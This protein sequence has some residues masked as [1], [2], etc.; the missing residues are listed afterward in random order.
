MHTVSKLMLAKRLRVKMIVLIVCCCQSVLQV[1]AYLLKTQLNFLQ[2]AS[3]HIS[4]VLHTQYSGEF[5][6]NHEYHCCFHCSYC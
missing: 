2:T 5:C 4:E 1:L 3:E 6:C